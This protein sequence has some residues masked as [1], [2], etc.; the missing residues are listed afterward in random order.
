MDDIKIDKYF[1]ALKLIEVL[2]EKGLIN[3]ETYA[4]IMKH[5]KCEE[6][7]TKGTGPATDK[8]QTVNQ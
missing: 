5:A 2:L 7:G 1:A 3:H 6:A 4:N 8:K